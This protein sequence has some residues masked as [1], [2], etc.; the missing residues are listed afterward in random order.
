MIFTASNVDI[1]FVY[2]FGAFLYWVESW[3]GISNK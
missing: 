3:Q 1:I 2:I